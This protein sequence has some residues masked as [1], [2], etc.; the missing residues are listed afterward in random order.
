[1]T[2]TNNLLSFLGLMKKAGRL[3]IGE[4]ATG[5]AARSGKARLI[6]HTTDASP[7]TVRKARRYAQETVDG[8]IRPDITKDEF[9]RAI[10]RES[11][12]IAA[13]CEAHFAKSLIGK[14][15]EE[16][17]ERFKSGQ[18]EKKKERDEQ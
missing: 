2:N 13:V 7:N 3:A 4:E 18:E 6:I 17:H 10:G 11:C 14:V 16:Q 5:D 12:A 1:M 15:P 9:G 8:L